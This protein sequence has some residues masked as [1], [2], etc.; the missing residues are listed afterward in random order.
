MGDNFNL[1]P[2]FDGITAKEAED[3][4]QKE[5]IEVPPPGA[6]KFM[7]N[8]RLTVTKRASRKQRESLRSGLKNLKLKSK[9]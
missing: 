9:G 8:Y 6:F 1:D 7:E 4:T 2:P 5:G 3:K